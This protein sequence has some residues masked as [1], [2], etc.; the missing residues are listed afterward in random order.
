MLLVAARQILSG[1]VCTSRLT[2]LLS[3]STGIQLA[4]L[5]Q[6]ALTGTLL[7]SYVRMYVISNT[8]AVLGA[9]A[10]S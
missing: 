1:R 2:T 8:Q 7:P 3:S 9:A 4:R 6:G 5:A 10:S